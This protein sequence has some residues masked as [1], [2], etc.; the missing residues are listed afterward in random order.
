MTAF[1]FPMSPLYIVVGFLV[2][3]R[4]AE[5]AVAR[6]NHL[7]LVAAGALEFGKRHY[8]AFVALHAGWLLALLATVDPR[9]PVSIP[10]LAV[11]VLL[12]CGR[13]WVIVTLGS[14]WTTRVMVVPGEKRIRSGPYRYVNHPN[15]L[16]V[17][18]EIAVVPLMFGAWLLAMIAFVLNLLVLR[19]RLRVENQALSEVYGQ[20]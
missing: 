9:T 12:E 2:L 7:A 18:G 8:P 1:T 19:T 14:R 6:R 10:L 13:V 3:Q 16:I 5:L 15:Y 20:A 11:F 4:L 17:C